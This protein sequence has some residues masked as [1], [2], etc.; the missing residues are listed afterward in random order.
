MES[1]RRLAKLC[2]DFRAADV[3][4]LDLTELTPIF[5]YF[6]IATGSNRRQMISLAEEADKVMKEQR[7]GRLGVEGHDAN[8]WVLHDY[9]DVVLHVFMPESRELYDLE[10]LWADAKRIDGDD[11]PVPS[12]EPDAE[13]DSFPNSDAGPDQ[14]AEEGTP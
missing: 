5:D 12:S 6:V 7:S 14:D 3:V 9:G 1:A 13:S 11:T 10:G 8:Q 4:L 2:K